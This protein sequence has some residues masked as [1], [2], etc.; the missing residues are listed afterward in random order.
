VRFGSMT[1][2]IVAVEGDEEK[3]IVEEVEEKSGGEKIVI[4]ENAPEQNA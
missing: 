2:T 3:K 4:E 1:K